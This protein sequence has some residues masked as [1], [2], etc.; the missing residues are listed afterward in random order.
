ML[1]TLLLIVAAALAHASPD[2]LT[3]E[4]RDVSGEWRQA[5]QFQVS[6]SVVSIDFD[7]PKSIEKVRMR[8][9]QRGEIRARFTFD[10]SPNGR[11][12]M[13]AWMHPREHTL[14]AF[15]VRSVEGKSKGGKA[16]MRVKKRHATVAPSLSKVQREHT[17]HTQ[18][19][20]QKQQPS[21]LVKYW[22]V[23]LP[24]GFL[25]LSSLLGGGGEASAASS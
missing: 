17:R 6:H 12:E 10:K 1:L 2:E 23:A 8:V 24:V 9:K 21:F 22:Y 15:A 3:L 16:H 25:L 7:L 11:Y 14:E 13:D 5:A 18:Q 20:Q 4:V 19:E